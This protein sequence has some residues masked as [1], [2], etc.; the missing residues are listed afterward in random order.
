MGKVVKLEGKKNKKSKIIKPVKDMIT[1]AL[2]QDIDKLCAALQCTR[3]QAI[4]TASDFYMQYPILV[5][6]VRNTE[7]TIRK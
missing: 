3:E 2:D 5:E 7:L 1:E 6:H 4:K